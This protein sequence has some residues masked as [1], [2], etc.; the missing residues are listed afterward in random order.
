MQRHPA[1]WRLQAVHVYPNK[2]DSWLD[3]DDVDDAGNGDGYVDADVDGD[4][5]DDGQD[6]V[7]DVEPR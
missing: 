4:E 5:S 1:T 3:N 6:A 2:N 7:D